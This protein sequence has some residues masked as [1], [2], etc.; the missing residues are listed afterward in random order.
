MVM[1]FYWLALA[2][3]SVWRVTHLLNAEDGPWNLVVRLRQVAGDGFW[4]SLLD[5]FYCLS[6]WIATPVAYFIG[7]R[8]MERIL[9]WLAL[10]A[11]AILIERMSAPPLFDIEE[12]THVL[13]KEQTTGAGNDASPG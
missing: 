7:S 4:G 1:Q 11:G 6:L 2:I 8:W 10:S 5:C 3:L 9:L 13:R 12:D